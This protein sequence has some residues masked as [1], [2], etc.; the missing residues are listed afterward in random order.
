MHNTHHVTIK[1]PPNE[2][3]IISKS[4]LISSEFSLIFQKIGTNYFGVRNHLPFPYAPV[5]TTIYELT[6]M[7]A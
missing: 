7:Q 3:Y 1:R 4:L 2:F 6:K 5:S